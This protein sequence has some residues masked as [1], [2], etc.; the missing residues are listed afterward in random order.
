MGA[1]DHVLPAVGGSG[2]ILKDEDRAALEAL[3]VR[4]APYGM[5]QFRLE[6]QN[7]MPRSPSR[8]TGSTSLIRALITRAPSCAPALSSGACRRFARR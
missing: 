7:S 3:D 1:N 5:A 4:L 8:P 2:G 6:L